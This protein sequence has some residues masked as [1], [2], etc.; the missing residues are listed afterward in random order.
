[1]S[2]ARG[3]LS[4][5]VMEEIDD[6]LRAK[7]VGGKIQATVDIPWGTKARATVNWENIGS[8]GTRDVMAAFG[9]YNSSTKVFDVYIAQVA[10]GQNANAGQAVTTTVDLEVSHHPELIGVMDGLVAVGSYNAGTSEFSSDDMEVV[11]AAINQK[12]SILPLGQIL[13]VAYSYV[14]Y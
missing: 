10:T 8:S 11:L 7:G 9:K 14:G 12:R 2:G 1:M 5:T 6:I 3:K 4:A 13:N